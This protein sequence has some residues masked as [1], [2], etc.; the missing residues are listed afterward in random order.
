MN[1]R[2][3]KLLSGEDVIG[4]VLVKADSY[5]VTNPVAALIQQQPN[6]NLGVKFMPWLLFSDDKDVEINAQVVVAV[7]NPTK[8]LLKGYEDA[9]KQLNAAKS[10]LIVPKATKLIME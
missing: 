9:I 2:G 3:L 10:G 4:R 1:I 5:N 7:Y 8:D 6:G